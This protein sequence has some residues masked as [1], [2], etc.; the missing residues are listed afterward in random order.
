MTEYEEDRVKDIDCGIARCPIA[1]MT[2]GDSFAD[3]SVAV[4]LRRGIT[5]SFSSSMPNTIE[6][7][8]IPPNAHRTLS[9][10][11]EKD[12]TLRRAS[13]LASL[14]GAKV[15]VL[16]DGAGSFAVG[17]GRCDSRFLE[18]DVFHDGSSG[19]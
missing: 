4:F 11:A 6:C 17:T 2:A 10:G 8:L 5:G 15:L 7:T 14:G 9:D 18:T 12:L 1:N 19:C 13:Y 3:E 16:K